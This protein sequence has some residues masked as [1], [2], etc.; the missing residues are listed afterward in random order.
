MLQ[1]NLEEIHSE[2]TIVFTLNGVKDD[3]VILSSILKEIN[4]ATL[5]K[6]GELDT[7]KTLFKW[8]CA[9]NAGAENDNYI[10]GRVKNYRYVMTQKE[11][12]DTIRVSKKVLMEKIFLESEMTDSYSNK[13]D[14]LFNFI[15]KLESLKYKNEHSTESIAT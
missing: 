13:I 7:F 8:L 6:L 9:L 15:E 12:D 11:L 1:T 4:N 14:S 2:P 10:N 3:Y 5:K